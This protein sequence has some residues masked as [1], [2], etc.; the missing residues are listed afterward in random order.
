MSI[1]LDT[2]DKTLKVGGFVL[3]GW[4]HVRWLER[5][6]R[7]NAESL[8]G[9]EHQRPEKKA[10]TLHVIHSREVIDAPV[11]GSPAGKTSG[12]GA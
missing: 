9:S 1:T 11:E 7:A 6:V 3:T 4:A 2:K 8:W 12:D 5:A 10:A